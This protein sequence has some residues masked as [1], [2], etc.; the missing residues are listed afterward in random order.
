MEMPYEVREDLCK[1]IR[2]TVNEFGREYL[3]DAVIIGLYDT[4]H[5]SDLKYLT[6]P[7]VSEHTLGNVP[8]EIARFFENTL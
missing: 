6:A 4:A 3:Q 8:F 5:V 2:N 1:R 7:T